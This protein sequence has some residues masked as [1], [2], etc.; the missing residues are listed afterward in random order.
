MLRNENIP[1]MRQEHADDDARVK[2]PMALPWM[3]ELA[4]PLTDVHSLLAPMNTDSEVKSPHY[5]TPKPGGQTT[6]FAHR[7]TCVPISFLILEIKSESPVDEAAE[8]ARRG[9]NA[10]VQGSRLLKTRHY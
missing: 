8:V 6:G 5:S 4:L 9:R 10:R 1:G 2:S 3:H 7:P